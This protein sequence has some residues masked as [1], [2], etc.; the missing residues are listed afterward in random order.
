[1]YTWFPS[2]FGRYGEIQDVILLDEW[3]FENNGKFSLN[4]HLYPAKVPTDF[5]GLPIKVGLIGKDLGVNITENSTSNDYKIARKTKD[6]DVEIVQ[7][8]CEKLNLTTIFRAPSID[9]SVESYLKEFGDLN[10]GLSDVLTGLISLIPFVVMSSFDFTIPY[11]KS[12]VKMFVP[13]PNAIP[14][15]EKVLPTFS[16]TVWLKIGLVLLL[17][18][19]VFWCALN[20]HYGSVCNETHTYQSLSICF[21]NASA[22]L[23][24]VS[25]PMQPTNP[26]LRVF[27][28]LYV[29]FCFAINTVFQAFFVYYLV[30]PKYGK[31]LETFDDLID[32]NVVYGYHP[33]AHFAK[34]TVPYIEYDSF[35]EHKKLQEEC[36]DVRICIQRMI[37]KRDI[38]II[39]T[40]NYVNS[41][42]RELGTE[43][44]LKIVCSFDEAVVSVGII[45][46]FKKGN[47]LLGRFNIVIR[48]YLET[49]FREK[50]W[51]EENHRNSLIG[52]W[53]FVQAA[54]DEYFAFSIPH[55]IPAFVILIVGA[56][57]GS[58]VFIAELV[59]NYL[60][61]RRTKNNSR[62]RRVI[63]VKSLCKSRGK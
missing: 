61:K 31:K 8:V 15:P 41:I 38:C 51:R 34:G 49:G 19:A 46:L 27:F 16:L 30:E 3:V 13:C 54:G 4:A 28:L 48:R 29:C 57:L 6:I 42:S 36:S 60:Y 59:V 23:L 26:S 21:H 50:M 39:H 47:P 35:L 20:G 25:V 33:T 1:L 11:E 12:S 9:F 62:F 32:Y 63:I 56:V 43:G 14:G 37:T 10:D 44:V 45:L 5:M 2:K 53:R 55:L 17:T 58:V 22:I 18:T 40:Q 52:E 24:A 7:L